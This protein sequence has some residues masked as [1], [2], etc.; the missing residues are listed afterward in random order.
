MRNHALCSIAILSLLAGTTRA[1]GGDSPVVG[2]RPVDDGDWPDAVAVLGANGRCSGTLIAPDVVLTAGHCID[3]DPA[4]VV[5]DSVDVDA[6]DGEWIEVSFAQAY[7]DWESSYDV[8]VLVL[9]DF[10]RTRPRK[11][12]RTCTAT[13]EIVAG[14]TLTV[15]GFGQT[16]EID[17]GLDRAAT[18]NAVGVTITDPVCEADPACAV[19]GG[20]LIAGGGGLD[21][22][23]GDSGGGAYADTEAGP[24]LLGVVSRGLAGQPACGGGGIYVRVDKVVRW[25]ERTTG[26]RLPRPTCAGASGDDPEEGAEAAGCSAAGGGGAGLALVVG[27]LGI[28]MTTRRRKPPQAAPRGTTDTP[29]EP[30]PAAS[31]ADDDERV[32]VCGCVRAWG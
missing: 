8:G 15:V 5:V 10:S 1:D 25:I 19:P 7:P 26:R 14:N 16:V 23:F 6:E 22:C 20:E 32:P 18:K 11:V 27:V 24:V 4:V 13:A 31:A 21:A 28:A 12:A 30:A 2:G 3:I 29:R 17:D 9:R